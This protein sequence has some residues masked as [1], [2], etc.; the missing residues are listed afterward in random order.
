MGSPLRIVYPQRVGPSAMPTGSAA[1]V[2]QAPERVAIK[3]FTF[4]N[5]TAGALA[6]TLHVVPV[7]GTAS[8]GNQI[9]P[10][11]SIPANDVITVVAPTVLNAGERLFALAANAVNLTFIVNDHE[12]EDL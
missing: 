12:T 7:G 10:A 4:A 6:V 8:V 5:T 2:Y 3:R 11:M 1:S 9:V